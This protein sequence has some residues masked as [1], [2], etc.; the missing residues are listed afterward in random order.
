M[1]KNNHNLVI[2]SNYTVSI[3]AIIYY[4]CILSILCICMYVFVIITSG[5][6]VRDT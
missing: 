5:L 3:I 4:L 1:K 2:H 6:V